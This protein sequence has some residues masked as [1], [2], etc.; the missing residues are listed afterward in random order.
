MR[1]KGERRRDWK[2][3]DKETLIR[4]KERGWE[5]WRKGRRKEK[6]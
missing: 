2:H 6:A 3:L 1:L 5:G 4:G